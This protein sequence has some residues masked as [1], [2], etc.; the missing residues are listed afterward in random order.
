MTSR[1]LPEANELLPNEENLNSLPQENVSVED[2]VNNVQPAEA[3]PQLEH[4]ET[5]PAEDVKLEEPAPQEESPEPVASPDS[6]EAPEP[7]ESEETE[8]VADESAQGY[9]AYQVMTKTELLDALKDL[10]QHPIEEVKNELSHLKQA[11]TNLRR[12]EV[13]KEK[14]DFIAGGGNEADFVAG[15][16]EAEENFKALLVVVK[17]KKAELAA[18]LEETKKENLEKKRAIIDEI[19]SIIND[20]D[21]VN[22][23]FGHV[24][25][26]QQKFREVGEVAA[27]ESSRI[28]KEFQITMEHFYD[29]LKMNKELRDYDFKKNLELKQQLCAEAEAL[30]DEEDVLAAFRKLQELHDKWRETGPVAKDIREELWVRFKNASSV[31][32]KKHQSYFEVRKEQE[33]TNAQ[34]KQE[35]CDRI[36]AISTDGLKT[37]AQWEN[38]TK[39]IIALQDEWKKLGF[40]SKKLN[41]ELFNRFR[42]SCDD[43]FEKKAAFFKA[44]KEELAANLAKKNE[45][46]E[47]AEALKDS[48]DWKKTTDELVALQKEWRKIGPVVKRHSES[49]W[50]RFVAACDHFFEQKKAQTTNIHAVEYDNLKQKREIIA[51]LKAALELEDAEQGAKEAR[52]LIAK[53]NSIG[54]VPYKEKDKIYAEYKEV[55]DRAFEKF[56]LR[57]SKASLASFESSLNEMG[58]SGRMYHERERLVRSYEQKCNELK[59]FE[60]NL[61]FLSARSKDGNVIVKE[62][63]KKISKIKD[64]ISVLEQKIKLIDSKE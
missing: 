62:M 4:A 47:R 39:E 8:I 26:L 37:Y 13:E 42:K 3:E 22:R 29:L 19:K 15:V 40:A 55:K 49:V 1:E 46:V 59:V 44:L 20:P 27:T 5:E 57:G 18:K 54:H 2:E 31:I 50:K 48:T 24:K 9:L 45:L 32:N 30:D 43:F 34:A 51:Q 56:D 63:E 36:E 28:W 25:E 23:Q 64:E 52:E 14:A 60:N 61:G 53:W 17:D 33:Q 10:I 11:F 41:N 58:D 38:K 35:L 21:N 12:S 6:E 7:A 16:D